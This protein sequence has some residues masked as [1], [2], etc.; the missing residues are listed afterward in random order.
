MSNQI[1]VGSPIFTDNIPTA[2]W[3]WLED[4][5][6]KYPFHT[7]EVKDGQIQVV[8]VKVPVENERAVEH[9]NY[10]KTSSDASGDFLERTFIP[11]YSSSRDEIIL[12]Q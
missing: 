5:K 3:K 11:R 7:M 9:L 1:R 8:R 12:E 4:I 2:F 10:G 6:E